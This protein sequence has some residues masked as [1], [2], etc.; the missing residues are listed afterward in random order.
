MRS[1]TLV[2]AVAVLLTAAGCNSEPEA[3]FTPPGGKGNPMAGGGMAEGMS[4][5]ADNPMTS[6]G[7]ADRDSN[8]ILEG[9]E[10]NEMFTPADANKDGKVTADEWKAFKESG[11]MQK[12]LNEA[13]KKK[14]DEKATSG[15]DASAATPNAGAPANPDAAA[16][17][18]AKTESK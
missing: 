14:A 8:K 3:D 9:S 16:P 6:F 5:M 4:K 7:Y 2:C 15:A 12:G 18:G 10:M 1:L 13:D 17:G 11:D